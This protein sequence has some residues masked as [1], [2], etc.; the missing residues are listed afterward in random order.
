MPPNATPP[1]KK[2]GPNKALSRVLNTH[3][4]RP[5]FLGEGVG[6][7]GVPFDSHEHICE[8]WACF[9]SLSSA[10]N[11]HDLAKEIILIYTVSIQMSMLGGLNIRTFHGN[12]AAMNKP[13]IMN[14]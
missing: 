10:T 8:K 6:I 9:K 5:Y 4:I 7:G 14:D 13:T 2:Y 3:L 1:P 12:K 11:S